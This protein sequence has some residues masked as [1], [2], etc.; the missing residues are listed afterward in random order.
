MPLRK[1]LTVMGTPLMLCCCITLRAVSTV[2]SGGSVMGSVMMPFSL[3][4]T[5]STSRGLV[6]HRHVL[7]DDAHPPSWASAIARSAS[8]TVS[9][10]EEMIGMFSRTFCVSWVRT[11]TSR[12]TTSL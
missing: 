8:V 9:I 3:R 10:G 1:P 2:S 6:R 7:V 4:L 5:L 11:S 12:G